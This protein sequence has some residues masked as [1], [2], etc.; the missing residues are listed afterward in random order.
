M[1]ARSKETRIFLLAHLFLLSV[2]LIG[3]GRTF[4]LRHLFIARPLPLVLLLHGIALTAWYG[5]V[6]L[7]GAMVLKG[8][9]EWHGRIAWLAAPVIVCVIY[10]GIQVNWNVARQITSAGDPENMFVWGNFMSLASFAILVGAGVKLRHRFMA[11][12]R[13][14]FFASLAI[15]GPAF[16]RFAFWPVVG[17][18]VGAAP[19][20]AIAGMLALVALAIGY[21]VAVFRRVQA[22]T[23]GGLA[24]VIVPLVAGT[25]VAISG[26]GY[27]LLHGA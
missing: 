13:M 14:I 3:F 20:F 6:A 19:L 21:D 22:A 10:S 17:L 4:Y 23:L 9:R 2:V 11:H 26:V 12:H 1:N 15:V 8:A 16:A 5:L 7:Q 24:G 27:A 25:A 18:G